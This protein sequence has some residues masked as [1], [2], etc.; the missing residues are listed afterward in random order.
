MI[1]PNRYEGKPFLRLLDCY[2]LK[3]IGHLDEAQEAALQNMEPKFRDAY[4]VEGTWFE[5][6]AQQMDFP[7]H[8][9]NE[10][11]RIWTEGSA[12]AA[13]MGL[14]AEPKE[15]TCQFVDNNFV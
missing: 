10:I 12:R 7:D 13:E 14:V 6:V 8:L 5:I 2:V 1:G 15:F 11:E 9:P 4:K 3:A